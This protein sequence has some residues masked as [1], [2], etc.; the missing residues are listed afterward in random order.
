MRQKKYIIGAISLIIVTLGIWLFF[1]EIKKTPKLEETA[2]P[3]VQETNSKKPSLKPSSEK[4]KQMKSAELPK[5]DLMDESSYSLSTVAE[6]AKLPDGIKNVV[7]NVAESYQNVYTT[8][9]EKDNIVFIVQELI[10]DK[11]YSRHGLRKVSIS[12]IDG[13]V[14]EK[15]IGYD[16]KD[17]E[18]ELDMWQYE[19]ISG[20]ELP[21]K[22]TKY[23][24]NK[25]VE[26]VET[27]NYNPDENIKY[28]VK[29]QFGKPISVMKETLEGDS[30]LRQEHVFY[31]SEGNT[32][33]NIS[34]SWE[35]PNIVRFT[36]FNPD[37]SVNNII[38]I[39]EY[40]D[41]LKTKETVYNSDYKLRNIYTSDYEE[42]VRKDIK[43]FDSDNKEVDKLLSK[44]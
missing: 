30:G 43:I 32:K 8:Y 13:K 3:Q 15:T 38:S 5:Y 21:V 36:Y 22:H 16:S 37:D 26:F 31:D 14:Q 40:Q 23:N 9:S 1:S 2:K 42:G 6:F 28:E 4:P 18:S 12:T 34:A 41:G 27:W 39:S 29:D 20:H 11:P 7:K 44:E 35:G 10:S 17:E 19:K 24:E 25:E 33:L